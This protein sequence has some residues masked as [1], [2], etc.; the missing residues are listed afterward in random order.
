MSWHFNAEQPLYMQISNVIMTRIFSGEYPV[1]SRIPSI[2]DL[3]VEAGVNPNTMQKAFAELEEKQIVLTNRTAGRV[4]TSDVEII[5]KL[6]FEMATSLIS[7]CKSKLENCGITQ[8]QIRTILNN[9][10]E[11]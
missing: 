11:N 5:D 1:S 3:A 4:V 10:S 6:R 9:I 8:Q 2:R 7:D